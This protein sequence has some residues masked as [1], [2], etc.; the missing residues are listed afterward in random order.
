[1]QIFFHGLGSLR[2]LHEFSNL[3][4]HQTRRNIISPESGGETV[5]GD[6]GSLWIGGTRM[7]PPNPSRSLQLMRC[8]LYLELFGHLKEMELL[9][10]GVNS[11]IHF[12]WFHGLL[13]DRWFRVHEIL[14]RA[15]LIHFSAALVIPMMGVVGDVV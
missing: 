2:Q 13:K 10:H 3:H 15:V 8:V 1:V 7:G 11:F 9:L 4:L 6:R 5:P 14:E 12:K